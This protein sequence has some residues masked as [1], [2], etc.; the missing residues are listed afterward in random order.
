VQGISDLITKVGIVNTDFND[1]KTTMKDQG[2]ALMG[3]GFGTGDHRAEEAAK[4]ALENPLLEDC[5][6]EGAKRILV[7][8]SGNEDISMV[9]YEE[10]NEYI[11]ANADPD[12]LVIIGLYE[13]SSLGDKLQVTVIATGFNS[14]VARKNASA[15]RLSKGRRASSDVTGL[16]EWESILGAGPYT[17]KTYSQNDLDVPA[18][19]R[20]GHP[21]APQ[22]TEKQAKTGGAKIGG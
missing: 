6:I 5:S 12:A 9:E 4:A 2:D 19:L 11:T 21:F 17:G 15:A 7:N 22:G 3:I 16:N 13:D 1:V 10:V 14:A 8:V 18:V 20:Y